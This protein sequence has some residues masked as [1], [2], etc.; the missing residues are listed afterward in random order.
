MKSQ[1]PTIN[2]KPFENDEGTEVV[3]LIWVSKSTMGENKEWQIMT[4]QKFIYPK[5]HFNRIHVSGQATVIFTVPYK[6]KTSAEQ[7]ARLI[8]H[9]VGGKFEKADPRK[10]SS[11]FSGTHCTTYL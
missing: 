3:N 7:A 10:A 4:C 1:L 2:I 8:A 11:G 6:N 5:T 9:A